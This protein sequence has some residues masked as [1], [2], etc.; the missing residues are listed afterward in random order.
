M[1]IVR[2]NMFT[3]SHKPTVLERVKALFPNEAVALEPNPEGWGEDVVFRTDNILAP[4]DM[5]TLTKFGLVSVRTSG[6]GSV[7]L[8]L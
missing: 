7:G 3:G 8:V 5:T 1:N 2:I 6:R 4:S